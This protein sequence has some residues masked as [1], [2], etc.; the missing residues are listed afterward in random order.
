MPRFPALKGD[1]KTDVLIIG[2]GIAG[3]LTAYFLD[4]QGV[5][6]I[7]AEK[8]HIC[9]GTTQN[10]TAKITF[11]HGLIYHKL[12]KKYGVEK[13]K[14]YLMANRL[15]FEKYEELCRSIDCD[16]E[17][18]NNYVYTVSDRQKIES[19]LDALQR[20]R[21]DAILYE[22]VPLPVK[23]SGA[24]MFP[25]QAQFHP[26][27]F[28]SS[29]AKDLNIYENTFVSEMK[30]NCAVTEFGKIYADKVIVATHFPF[31]NK[32]GSYYMKLYQHRSYVIALENAG[33]IDGMYV[34]DDKKGM[35]FRQYNDLLLLGGGGHRTGQHGGSFN[36]LRDFA[37]SK[38]PCSKEKYHWAAQDCISLDDIPYIGNYSKRTTDLYV[39]TGFNKW[40][41]TGAMIAA[42]LL[43]DAIMQKDNDFSSLFTP[44]RNMIQPRLFMN[45]FETVKSLI[46]PT[47]RRCPHLGCALKWNNAEHS[48]DC[49]CHG[50][51]ID[52]NG[53]VL[54]N[55]ANKK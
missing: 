41:I 26:L 7:L 11:Q 23:T 6:Y 48:W 9:S 17:K 46:T 22:D 52:K 35:S 18:K 27:K 55:P 19:E 15:A 24:V 4:K 33:G 53:S 2:G 39:A 42:T 29:I 47:S 50:T 25:E 43:N 13:A 21:F 30:D 5:N 28:V 32:H 8:N 37:K 1:A 49:S 36:E 20:I 51:R 14:G 45:S 44:S 40:G 16:F 31:I 54:D 34:D 10:T 38:Y 12:I 3:I